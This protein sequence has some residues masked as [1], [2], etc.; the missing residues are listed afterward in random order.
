MEEGLSNPVY[1]K[2]V[3]EFTTVANEYC[4]FVENI[5]ELD[6]EEII[7]KLHKLFP[8]LYLKASLLPS[9]DNNFEEYNEK[10]VTEEDYNFI[11]QGFVLKLN[12]YDRYEEVFDPMRESHDQPA[13]TTISEN[14]ADMYQDLKNF[15]LLFQIGTI[16]VMHE[17]IREVFQNFEEYWGQKLVNGLRALHNLKY[18]IRL[19]DEIIANK[20][21]SSSVC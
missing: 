13:L 3:I 1:S 8:L 17:A 10:Y 16:E 19:T 15:I 9:L 20:N 18:N 6:V 12:D 11:K 5:G 7:D 14:I 21:G 2:Q 4:N